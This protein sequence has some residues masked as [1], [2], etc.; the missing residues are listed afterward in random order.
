MFSIT[1]ENSAADGLASRYTRVLV[2]DATPDGAWC[3]V[4]RRLNR[5]KNINCYHL[6]VCDRDNP[7]RIVTIL[8]AR[9]TQEI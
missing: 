7:H 9:I 8:Q 4:Y 6:E 3:I 2:L 5:L 1:R